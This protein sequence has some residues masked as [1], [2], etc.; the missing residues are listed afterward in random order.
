M[1]G[2]AP[3]EH[4]QISGNYNF[5]TCGWYLYCGNGNLYSQNRDEGRE[6]HGSGLKVGQIIE[7]KYDKE[8]E[9]IS[10]VV[11]GVNCGVAYENINN[12]KL[13]LFA[14]FDRMEPNESFELIE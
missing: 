5:R 7:V 9:R 14:A 10:Y 1:I 13:D 8:N 3:K 12:E 6:Y 4:F 11:D 2:L